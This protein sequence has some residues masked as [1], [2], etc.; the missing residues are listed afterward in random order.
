M[1]DGHVLL[2]VPG[3]P[4]RVGEQP[5]VADFLVR[6]LHGGRLCR[7]DGEAR[8]DGGDL[9]RLGNLFFVGRSTRT[10]DAGIE[11]LRLL[12]DH[13]GYELR[14]VDIPE[15]ALHLTSISS[16]PT[17]TDLFIPEGYLTPEDFGVVAA[18]MTVPT[19][20]RQ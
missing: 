1:I 11:E 8:M 5:P 13:L 3:H 19:W 4:S 15:N 2:P 18:A 17:D 14:V 16:T 20:G 10:N 9:L 6:Q 7:M 12:L